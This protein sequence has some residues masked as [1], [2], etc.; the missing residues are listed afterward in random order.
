MTKLDEVL[1]RSAHYSDAQGDAGL[2][3]QVKI[4]LDCA[5]A[6]LNQWIHREGVLAT[7]AD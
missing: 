7:R 2:A 3:E 6:D 4:E 5:E 1:T